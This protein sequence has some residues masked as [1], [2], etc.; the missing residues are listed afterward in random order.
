MVVYSC[1]FQKCSFQGRT[2]E[3]YIEHISVAHGKGKC[4]FNLE[5]KYWFKSIERLLSH[6]ENHRKADQI[7][8]VQ[9]IA[10]IAKIKL[11]KCNV[12]SC[13]TAIFRDIKDY[14]HHANKHKERLK[15]CMFK[16][17][18]Y[19]PYLNHN[20]WRYHLKTHTNYENLYSMLR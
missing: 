16:G 18:D 12:E 7:R 11:I 6:V 17:C 20:S 15:Y 4:N 1:S 5:C 14:I 10:Q 2:H 8:E 9:D 3:V 13:S 19:G